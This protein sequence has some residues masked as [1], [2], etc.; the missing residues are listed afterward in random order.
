MPTGQVISNDVMQRLGLVDPGGTAGASDS[1]TVLNALNL[2]WSGWS[3]DESMIWGQ[4]TYQA[5]LSAGRAVYAIGTGGDFATTRPAR[6]YKAFVMGTV[7]FTATTTLGSRILT[8]ISD[9]SNLALGQQAIG[10][11]IPA[12]SFIVGIVTNTSATISNLA[13]SSINGA[14]CFVT[15]GN[16]NE[17]RIVTAGEY[18]DHNDLGALARTPDELYPDYLTSG[19]GGTMNLYL[20]PV[21][22]TAPLAL[23]LDMAVAFSTWTLAGNYNLPPGVQD[24]VEWAVAFR[25]LPTFGVAVQQQVAAVVTA[26]GQKAEARMK[27]ANMFARQITPPAPS[28]A[29]AQQAA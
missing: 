26:E 18:Y 27:A 21:P 22:S 28:Q 23:E 9:T 8:A 16:R 1:A 24:A 25:L 5:A 29:P 6:I 7:A 2:M 3:V 12:N 17:L 14:A 15:T 19:T 13:T 20:F 10:P 4:E 11:G